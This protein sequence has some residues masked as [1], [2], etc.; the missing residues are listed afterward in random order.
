MPEVYGCSP[1]LILAM[2]TN[3]EEGYVRKSELDDSG[4]PG[5]VNNPE[6]ALAYMEWLETQPATRNIPLYDCEG[7]VIGQFGVS[8]PTG[9]S[10]PQAVVTAAG[11][12]VCHVDGCTVVAQH[13][14]DGVT[15]CGGEA[16][17][18]DTCDGSCIYQTAASTSS[19]S[20]HE[21]S[22]HGSGHH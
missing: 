2:G 11:F 7:N 18:G 6:E 10:A 14:H 8:N 20:H 17:H 4:Y 13:T 19:G 22:H 9:G 16:H 15:Y 5:G 3:G 12:P 21:E 1:D